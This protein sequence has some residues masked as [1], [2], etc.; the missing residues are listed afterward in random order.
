M[1]YE[2]ESSPSVH[3]RY[4]INMW[5]VKDLKTPNKPFTLWD[6]DQ[7]SSIRLF[8]FSTAEHNRHWPQDKH[9]HPSRIL[10][11]KESARGT[12]HPGFSLL[13]FLCPLMLASTQRFPCSK[14]TEVL[15]GESLVIYR[16]PPA[17]RVS[18]APD[19]S[20]MASH[21]STTA[22]APPNPLKLLRNA[23]Q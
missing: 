13:G 16:A 20:F 19:F 2:Q 22:D 14:T 7:D 6:P 15:P 10:Q 4:S 18:P 5:W 8:D 23:G 1:V 12:K 21:I 3:S 9:T 11:P 17:T